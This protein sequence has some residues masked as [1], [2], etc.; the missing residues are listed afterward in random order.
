MSTRIVRWVPLAISSIDLKNHRAVE[1]PPKAFISYSHSDRAKVVPL[2]SYFDHLGVE[3]WMD[4][5][6]LRG[7]ESIIEA[8]S[9]AIAN[10]D[11]YVVCLSP[12]SV[13]SPWVRQELQLALTLETQG[14][15]PRVLPVLLSKTDIPAALTGRLYIDMNTPPDAGRT[16]IKR[17]V[18][19][20]F[21]G[22]KGAPQPR[23]PRL[24]IASVELELSADT[25][26][27][28]GG[29]NPEVTRNE[30]E[31]E[32][33]AISRDLQRRANGV[34]LNFLPISEVDLTAAH[35][36]FANGEVSVRVQDRPGE[37]TGTVGKSVTTAVQ[38]IN[39]SEDK[40]E[41]LVSSKL[42][43]LG[44]TKV[45]Y[46]FLLNPLQE[47]LGQRALATLQR[48]FIL[49]GWDPEDGADIEFED[50]LRISVLISDEQI[51]IGLATRFAFQFDDRAKSF[52]VR[53]FVESLIEE[54][55]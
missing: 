1:K 18:E 42:K 9:E 53:H 55:R 26:L 7:G 3:V 47:G 22:L 10:S 37:L 2:A 21:S 15:K 27:D 12:S 19:A 50:D 43:S 11:I 25:A 23:I 52:S 6:D 32:A 33:D 38:I 30:V 54:S 28:Y 14:E 40:L 20:H 36:Q 17:F 29:A 46:T 5:K 39:P 4:T 34:L 48:K 41:N 45:I 24:T 44:V 16:E 49:L 13:G 51:R 35:F 31:V 8:V